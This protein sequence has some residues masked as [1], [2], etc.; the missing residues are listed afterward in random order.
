M[1]CPSCRAENPEGATQCQNCG[2]ALAAPPPQ[3]AAAGAPRAP[4]PPMVT[5]G[6]PPTARTAPP[7]DAMSGKRRAQAMVE[8]Q[9]RSASARRKSRLIWLLSLIGLLVVA[10][11][12]G[13]WYL[14]KIAPRKTAEG[15][16]AAS[17]DLDVARMRALATDSSGSLLDELQKAKD[18]PLG[19]FGVGLLQQAKGSMKYEVTDVRCGL[20]EGTANV[21]VRGSLLGKEFSQTEKIC[22]RRQG[23]G[24]RVDVPKT[25]PQVARMLGMGGPPGT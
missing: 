16:V 7:V 6:R 2:A 8:V 13:G 9:K 5:P 21:N 25:W 12:G 17:M 1:Q 23:L 24:W 11:G 15:F 14:L 19:A 10:G 22:L 3:R 18:S 4:A 20:T